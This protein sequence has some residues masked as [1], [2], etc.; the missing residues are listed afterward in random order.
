MDS[1]KIIDLAKKTIKIEIDALLQGLTVIDDQFVRV[2]NEI[3]LIQN[4]GRVIIMGMGKSGHIGN[5]IA[6]T[7]SSTGT[8][9]FFIHPAEAGHGDLGMLTKNDIIIAISQSGESEEI[10]K[11][12]P[13]FKRRSIKV[14]AMTGVAK[15]S[16]SRLSDYFINTY[17]PMEAC[18]LG[19]A[20]T[21]STTLTL[22]LGDALAVCL[23]QKRGF[24]RDDFASTHPNG[25]LGRKLLIQVKDVMYNLT[26]AP[27][28]F[29]SASIKD[30]IFE[31][32]SKGLGFVVI[33]DENLVPVGI[34]TDGDL[35]RAL[36]KSSEVL[37]GKITD[38]MIHNFIV[39]EEKKL[40]VEAI[41][42]M[43]EHKI[44][45]IPVV[46]ENGI[47]AGALNIRI[48]LQAGIV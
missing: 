8:P 18:P 3:E 15:S 38:F 46:N 33:V 36:D 29:E 21:S 35:R 6:A 42:L 43:S 41:N 47:L 11:L 13:F 44:S 5:K 30:S 48:L 14:V 1:E 17:V 37:S 16:L 4:G 31:I 23:L 19:L 10:L 2:I 34:F 39:I 40:C 32:S 26:N 45:M 27:Y 7:L 20:P 12:I 9:S 24:T 28:V 25:S 22:A